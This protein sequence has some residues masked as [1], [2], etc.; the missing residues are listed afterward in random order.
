MLKFKEALDVANNGT[1]TLQSFWD[2]VG[3]KPTTS[4]GVFV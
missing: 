1:N 4:F 3:M 2:R